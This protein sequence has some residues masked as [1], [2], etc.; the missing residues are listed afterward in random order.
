ME[1]STKTN[2]DY[3]IAELLLALFNKDITN[4]VQSKYPRIKPN[5]LSLENIKSIALPRE[6]QKKDE[7]T[8]N[9][10]Y[11]NLTNNFVPTESATT[12]VCLPSSTLPAL[13]PKNVRIR[14]KR[15][16]K[17]IPS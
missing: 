11:G 17:D 13:Q 1:S 6:L 7:E 14:K 16:C 10:F 8:D 4:S 9:N 12:L 5:I 15:K 2:E 3:E